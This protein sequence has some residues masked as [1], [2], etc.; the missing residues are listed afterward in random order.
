[1]PIP[2]EL[3]ISLI[4]GVWPLS[5][6]ASISHLPTSAS[7]PSGYLLFHPTP[8][9]VLAKPLLLEMGQ[10]LASA[11]AEVDS[12]NVSPTATE[13]ICISM[14]SKKLDFLHFHRS[15]ARQSQE[16]AH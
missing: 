11:Q 9:V 5:P 1:M 13:S 2:W 14:F 4:W 7:V 8:A 10:S 15:K 3:K 6:F 16:I 12:V